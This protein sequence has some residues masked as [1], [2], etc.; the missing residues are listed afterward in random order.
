MMIIS[1][2]GSDVLV[3]DV[4]LGCG[5]AFALATLIESKLN[6]PG[7]GSIIE[8]DLRGGVLRMGRLQAIQV[9]KAIRKHATLAQVCRGPVGRGSIRGE[10]DAVDRVDD[11][12]GRL[13]RMMD[14]ARND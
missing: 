12:F 13:S 5:S 11:I 6:T 1:H 3:G 14:G 9:V 8:V 10:R 4:R 7:S 2:K